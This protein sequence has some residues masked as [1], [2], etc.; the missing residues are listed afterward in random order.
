M[1]IDPLASTLGAPA[2]DP[3]TDALT[4]AQNGMG[5]DEFLK[6]L[7]TQIENQDP[8]DPLK[9]HEFVAQL[10]QFSALEQQIITNDSLSQMQQSQMSLSN[11]QLTNMIGKEVVA[12]GD[13]VRIAG[14]DA[15]SIGLM[16]PSAASR[17]EITVSDQNGN[18]V[19]QVNR[20]RL[21]PGYQD[22]AWNGLNVDG[23][24]LADGRYHV[25]VSAVDAA[26]NPMTVDTMTRGRVEAVTFENG[27]AELIVGNARVVP[28]DVLSIHDLVPA[29]SPSASA[30]PSAIPDSQSQAEPQPEPQSPPPAPDQASPIPPNAEFDPDALIPDELAAEGNAPPAWFQALT[31]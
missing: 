17:V 28:G 25:S 26:G 13:S 20:D 7:T 1:S 19:A 24:P 29:A 4:S 16:L 2:P 5:R 18:A 23:Q 10:A 30:P 27:I 15:Q 6:L 31:R 21:S 11:A 8:L 9:N 14:G 12:R 3:R 22:V